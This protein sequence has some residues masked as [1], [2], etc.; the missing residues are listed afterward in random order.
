MSPGA[1][2]AGSFFSG[3][4]V[5][6]LVVVVDAPSAFGSAGWQ[7][8]ARTDAQRAAERVLRRIMPS[9]VGRC[10]SSHKSV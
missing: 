8:R 6:V 9:G 1:G 2:R 4:V 10:R 7:P 5:E 3:V